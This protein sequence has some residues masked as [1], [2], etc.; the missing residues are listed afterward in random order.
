MARQDTENLFRRYKGEAVALK[1]TSGGL[2]Q[3]RVAEIT[4]DYVVLS[5]DQ[6]GEECLVSFFFSSIESVQLKKNKA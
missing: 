1:T 6:D 4:N 2:Y 3:G 5:Q